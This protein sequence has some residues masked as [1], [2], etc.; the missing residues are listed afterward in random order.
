MTISIPKHQ[1]ALIF[2]G[3]G[4]LGAYEVGFYQSVYDRYVK[5]KKFEHPF[6]VIVG[7]SIGAINGALLV[8]YFKKNKS[9]HGTSE[10]LKDFWKY[11]STETNFA[12]AFSAMWNS[13]RQFFPEAPSKEQARRL[14]AVQ[15]QLFTG[16]PNVF[17][18]PKL[19]PDN[20][21]LG[22][23]NHW[24]Q[25][26]NEGLKQS[27]EKFIDFPIATEF[28]KN[29]PRLLLVAVDV[30]ESL[31]VVFDSYKHANG[32]R[33]TR[34]GQ[35][36]VNGKAVGGFLIEYEG[37]EVEHILASANVPINYDYTKITAKEISN[38]DPDKG[39][40]VTR[41]MWDGGLL[42]N[43]PLLPL[44]VYHKGF[45]DR[46]IGIEKQRE[47][48]LEDDNTQQTQIPTLK[49]FIV[50]MWSKKSKK[51]PQTRNETKSR[52]YEIMYSDKT[53]YEE[54]IM[55]VVDDYVQMSKKLIHLAK[56][57]GATKSE[58]EKILMSPIDTEFYVGVKRSYI[59][60]IRGRFPMQIYRIQREDDPDDIADQA[61]DFS[62]KTIEKL[63][64]EGYSDTEKAFQKHE[65]SLKSTTN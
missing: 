58:L 37:V 39:K 17:S 14:F 3:G 49:T 16:V 46:Y 62:T 41:Y 5:T 32:K 12:D 15:E 8:S 50:D 53:E 43:T 13:W 44:I 45:W 61:F 10:H 7:T 2:Q 57:K 35:K 60:L 22:L 42:H 55:S 26:S 56:E 59:D 33:E 1:R 38:T 65:K 24:Y 25:S 31:P 18:I 34:Y 19:R 64:Q 6:D 48:V 20:Q 28:E 4:A 54:R 27:L 11:L 63:I 36:S 51:I 21:F 30:Q 52:Y 23:D 9:W 47:V 29:E 40:Q